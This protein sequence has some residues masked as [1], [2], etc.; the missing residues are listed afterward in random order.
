[1]LLVTWEIIL[2]FA[3][4]DIKPIALPANRHDGLR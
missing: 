4:F 1:M 3:I 2:W